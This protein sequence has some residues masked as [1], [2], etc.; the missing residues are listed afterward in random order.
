MST[1]GVRKSY[2]NAIECFE[3]KC[4]D[5]GYI[6]ESMYLNPSVKVQE[7]LRAISAQKFRI[8]PEIPPFTV[9]RAFRDDYS[10]YNN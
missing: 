5:L 2:K 7:R 3:V 1:E 10:H 8:N 4:L 9:T 6:S